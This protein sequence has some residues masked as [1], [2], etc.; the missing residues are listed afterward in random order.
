[1]MQPEDIRKA[2]VKDRLDRAEE[3][4]GVARELHGFNSPYL[5]AIGFHAQQAAEKYLKALLTFRQREFPR[6]H[7]LGVL[8]ETVRHSDP[9][10][11]SQLSDVVELNPFAIEGRY[12][13]DLNERV[14]QHDIQNALRIAETVKDLVRRVLG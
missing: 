14:E 3:D 10:I 7:D 11:A 9:E 2:L 13:G 5:L 1:M 8:L 6:T 12:P 4:F